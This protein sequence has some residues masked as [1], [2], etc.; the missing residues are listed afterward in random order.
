MAR[1]TVDRPIVQGVDVCYMPVGSFGEDADGR[2]Y[3]RTEY[4]AAC[5]TR[6]G[7]SYSTLSGPTGKKVV[8]IP[9]GSKI[10]ISL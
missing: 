3:F 2:I 10:T 8:V 7:C 1:I 5:L 9:A 6:P 4:T